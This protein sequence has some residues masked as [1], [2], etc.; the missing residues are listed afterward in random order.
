MVAGTI[1][2][3]GVY[4]LAAEDE[5]E[6][7]INFLSIEG[8]LDL[9]FSP[10]EVPTPTELPH[11]SLWKNEHVIVPQSVKVRS[12][13]PEATK[14]VVKMIESTATLETT[15]HT[16][17]TKTRKLKT[18]PT[19]TSKTSKIFAEPWTTKPTTTS[20][21]PTAPHIPG[22]PLQNL[23]KFKCDKKC[24][25][26][27]KLSKPVGNRGLLKHLQP[28]QTLFDKWGR[29]FGN[30][31]VWNNTFTD[32]ETQKLLLEAD[33]A[34]KTFWSGQGHEI[35]VPN[36]KLFDTKIPEIYHYTWFTCRE[37]TL[38]HYMSMVSV[39][40]NMVDKENGRFVFHTDCPPDNQLF[41]SIQSILGDRIIFQKVTLFQAIWNGQA[42]LGKIVHISDVYR[43]YVLYRFGGI[44]SALQNFGP[45][46]K[47]GHF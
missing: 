19:T 31:K 15:T 12:P 21:F 27:Q 2:L 29:G 34:I 45:A 13:K 40:K 3:Y 46:P 37:F 11:A 1:L 25:T 23:P 47:F 42:R 41:K 8:V 36:S 33:F 30:L 44:Y 9:N 22:N 14:M 28:S 16:P 38:V 17:E 18:T 4:N 10:T 7:S 32:L 43:L 6:N 5:A 35:T 26:P 39:V 20:P 24:E